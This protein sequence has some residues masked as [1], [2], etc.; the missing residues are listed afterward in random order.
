MRSPSQN[1]LPRVVPPPA[2]GTR[3]S[4]GGRL[5]AVALAMLA[6]MTHG[7]TSTAA[8]LVGRA[9]W[10]GYAAAAWG[11]VFALPSFYW[12]AGGVAGAAT[13]VAPALVR[14]VQERAMWFIVVLWV[15]GLLKVVGGLL[16]LALVGS[17][18][19]RGSP[20][21]QL[22]GCG[23]GVLLVWH[24]GL[25][26]VQGLLVQSGIVTIAPEL[27]SVSRWY[28]YLWGPWFMAGG[29]LFIMAA[30][31]HLRSVRD[32]RSGAIAGA[33]GGFGALGL[34]V[35]MLAAGIG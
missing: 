12:A 5:S 4:R 29:L 34:S 7:F 26:L 13:T 6:D 32:R 1:C 23:A 30:R 11:L 9:R 18:G 8:P 19:R 33:V 25:F 2:G 31:I 20:L 16:G 10:P 35:A 17:W 15:T 3:P 14:L 21:L 24:G 27:L 28:T 22:A